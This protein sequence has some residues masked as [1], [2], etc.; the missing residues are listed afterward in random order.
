MAGGEQISPPKTKAAKTA[1]L[2]IL[3]LLRSF[4]SST[5]RRQMDNRRSPAALAGLGQLERFDLG[6]PIEESVDRPEELSPPF[7]V[8]DPDAEN[9]PLAAGP[10]ILGHEILD[11]GGEKRM[12]VELAVDRHL[13]QHR[14]ERPKDL[15]AIAGDAPAEL[16]EGGVVLAPAGR[17]DNGHDDLPSA[18]I[19]RKRGLRQGRESADRASG[20][21]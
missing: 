14:L 13:H 17:T 20:L 16:E 15:A 4:S 7:A 11:L 8:D 9:A 1:F 2:M 6:Q 5:I 19:G 18:T 3:L 12:Q 10:K 21:P